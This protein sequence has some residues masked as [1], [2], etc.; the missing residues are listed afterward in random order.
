MK[1]VS[2]REGRLEMRAS[3]TW[4]VRGEGLELE[5]AAVHEVLFSGREAP[6]M[7]AMWWAARQ[8]VGRG[9]TPDRERELNPQPRLYE[10]RAL[11]LSYLGGRASFSEAGEG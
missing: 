3:E 2:C 9:P 8:T 4:R 11:P 1:W 5:S 10:S 6:V 7:P